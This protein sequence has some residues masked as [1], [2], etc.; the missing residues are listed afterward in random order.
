[1]L[2]GCASVSWQL[3]CFCIDAPDRFAILDRDW[4][5]CGEQVAQVV[6]NTSRKRL[7]S[8]EELP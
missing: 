2:G 7:S 5:L 3:A 8:R 6:D 4:L 1:M